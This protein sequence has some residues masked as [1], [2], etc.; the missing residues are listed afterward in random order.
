M[1]EN[2]L[3][4][5]VEAQFHSHQIKLEQKVE[6]QAVQ[7]K[8]MTTVLQELHREIGQLQR[9]LHQRDIKDQ[10]RQREHQREIHKLKTELEGSRL[11]FVH[12][13]H[14]SLLTS[15][16]H[17]AALAES[18]VTVIASKIKKA[19]HQNFL[20]NLIILN[21]NNSC[22]M[23]QRLVPSKHKLFWYVL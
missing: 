2:Q 19:A 17:T 11:Y 8:E 1:R 18:A 13:C 10:E 15:I 6:E 21:S 22:F 23:R 7:M 12:S 20:R 9:E 14:N 16:I 3:R 4:T 5:Q